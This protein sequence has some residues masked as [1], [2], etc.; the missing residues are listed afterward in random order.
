MAVGDADLTL[1]FSRLDRSDVAWAGG[2]GS[3]LGELVVA[4]FP[5]P[6]GFVV[7]GFLF[8]LTQAGWSPG[9]AVGPGSPLH[10]DYLKATGMTF[11]GITACQVGTAFAARTTRASLWQIGP[12]S[13]RLL[14]GGIAFELFFAAAVIYLPPLQS[15][16]HTRALGVQDLLLLATFPVIVWG[17]DELRRWFLRSRDRRL[18]SG[19][20]G[21]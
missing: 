11:A 12:F 13:N 10:E 8:V 6:K 18:S 9:D 16:F 21:P 20:T 3:N 14:L 7:G 2:K 17:T 1:A 15:V 5:V 4:G 19:L